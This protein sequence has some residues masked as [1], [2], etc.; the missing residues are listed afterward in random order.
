MAKKYIELNAR[1]KDNYR[2]LV[3]L[4]NR[5]I[6]SAQKVY[7]K[8]GMD[9]LPR[10]V[11]G[12]YQLIE[13]WHTKTTPLSRSIKFESRKAYNKQLSFLR[14]FE[15]MRPTMTEYT[16]VQQDKLLLAIETSMGVE[17]PETLQAKIKKMTAPQLSQFW[18]EFSNKATRIG[19]KYSSN[20]NMTDTVEEL[21]PEDLEGLASSVELPRPS[22]PIEFR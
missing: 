12:E 3:Q 14:T 17:A 11:V 6:K 8:A 19:F 7:S 13:D 5:R 21:F 18:N 2:R 15:I 22:S 4:A 10:E 20:S 16:N 9:I 1:E